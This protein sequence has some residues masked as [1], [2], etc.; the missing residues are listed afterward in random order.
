[1]LLKILSH[2]LSSW[3]KITKNLKFTETQITTVNRTDGYLMDDDISGRGSSSLAINFKPSTI[4]KRSHVD[5][6]NGVVDGS[7]GYLDQPGIIRDSDR[8]I[9]VPNCLI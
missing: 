9:F 2:V 1:M 3:S 4:R 7:G 5:A 8:E 6:T